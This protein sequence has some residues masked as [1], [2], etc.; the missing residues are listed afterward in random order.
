MRLFKAAA[1]A[2]A[3]RPVTGRRIESIDV[4]GELHDTA[5]TDGAPSDRQRTAAPSPNSAARTTSESATRGPSHE[6]KNRKQQLARLPPNTM[7]P[8]CATHQQRPNKESQRPHRSHCD[9]RISAKKLASA[10]EHELK[11]PRESQDN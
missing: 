10:Q 4:F 1:A 2:A 3:D 7:S 5:L 11:T 9:R 8:L 6:K